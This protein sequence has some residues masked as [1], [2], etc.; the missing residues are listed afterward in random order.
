MH[1][2][3]LKVSAQGIDC[4]ALA[5]KEESFLPSFFLAQA[6]GGPMWLVSV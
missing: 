3:L 5:R 2:F 4:V 6:F 1:C